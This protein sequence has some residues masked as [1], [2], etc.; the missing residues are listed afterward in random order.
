[1]FYVHVFTATIPKVGS[2]SLTVTSWTYCS[3]TNF[4]SRLVVAKKGLQ[5]VVA[6]CCLLDRDWCVGCDTCRE[7][8]KQACLLKKK[9]LKFILLQQ[10][11][12]DRFSVFIPRTLFGLWIPSLT[13]PSQCYKL[14][15]FNVQCPVCSKAFNSI[16]SPL[17]FAHCSQSYLICTLSGKPMDEHNPPMMLP[18]GYIYGE[19]VSRYAL[20]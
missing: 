19:Q 16:A 12:V 2:Y 11:Q 15:E 6:C 18:N 3:S 9:F 5:N 10:S 17:P 7:M 20:T 8:I 13:C 1:M 4:A 14:E